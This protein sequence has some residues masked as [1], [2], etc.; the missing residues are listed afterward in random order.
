MSIS[1]YAEL[2]TAI[3]NWLP[4]ADLTSRIP[5]FVTLCESKLNRTLRC[6]QMEQRATSAATEYLALPADFL[7][8]RNIQ[9]NT[10]PKTA[11]RLASPEYMDEWM[12]DSS[13]KPR[14]YSVLANQIQL[15]P[16]PDGT[17][18]I[19]IDYYESIPPLASNSTN[20]LLTSHP[21]I[22][23]YGSLLESAAFL[24]GSAEINVWQS[25]FQ[26]CLGQLQSS[27]RRSKWSGSSMAVRSSSPIY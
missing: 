24:S 9:L 25:A 13:G 8:L 23:L 15:A 12:S 26:Q 21:D 7:E 16:V 10:T 4:R 17:Y 18:T 5:E 20:W 11:L 14:Y 6:R 22:Y 19:E 1:T 27:D 2:Q 3:A